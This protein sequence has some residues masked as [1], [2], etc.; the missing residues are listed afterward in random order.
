MKNNGQ[1]VGQF[2]I[3]DLTKDTKENVQPKQTVTDAD[4]LVV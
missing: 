4:P 2:I 3:C 1:L